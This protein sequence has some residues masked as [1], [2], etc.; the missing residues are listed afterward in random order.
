MTSSA[1]KKTIRTAA[2][3]ATLLATLLTAPSQPLP[4][5]RPLAASERWEAPASV[6]RLPMRRQAAHC[7]EALQ[8]REFGKYYM[9]VNKV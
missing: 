3:R 7:E 6:A 8:S 9:E 1:T 4:T 2:I 5:K